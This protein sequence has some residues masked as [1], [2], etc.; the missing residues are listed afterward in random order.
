[1]LSTGQKMDAERMKKAGKQRI[2]DSGADTYLQGL[3][4]ELI[5][6]IIESTQAK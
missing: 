2:T 6:T 5:E 1:M 4:W 3:L